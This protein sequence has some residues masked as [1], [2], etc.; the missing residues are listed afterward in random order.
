MQLWQQTAKKAV[1]WFMGNRF[2]FH[3]HMRPLLREA[4]ANVLSYEADGVFFN[5][6]YKGHEFFCGSSMLDDKVYTSLHANGSFDRGC[7]PLEVRN[8]IARLDQNL[9]RVILKVHTGKKDR[10]I[11][12][13]IATP[14]ILSPEFFC[15][16]LIEMANVMIDVEETLAKRY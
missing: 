9:P 8:A 11:A 3:A 14:E 1:D 15:A 16:M 10:I 12:S 4:G 5:V 2:D 6:R 13:F 7:T